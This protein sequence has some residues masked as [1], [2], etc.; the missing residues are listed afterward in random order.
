MIELEGRGG[1][2]PPHGPHHAEPRL[3]ELLP[4]PQAGE[5]LPGIIPVS[6]M[7]FD[8]GAMEMPP[9]VIML[10]STRLSSQR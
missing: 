1:E 7:K 8:S 5:I 6:L 10:T 2:M 9:P 3:R 4:D